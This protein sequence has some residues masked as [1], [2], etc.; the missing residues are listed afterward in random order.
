[1]PGTLRL[2]NGSQLTYSAAKRLE[3]NVIHSLRYHNLK[4]ALYTR[5]A[6]QEN[7]IQ[8][9]AAHHLGLRLSECKVSKPVD[10][11]HGSCNLC[12]PID[13]LRPGRHACTRVIMRFPLA[14]RVGE[15]FRPGNSDEKLRTEAGTYAWLQENCPAVPIPRLYGF[16]LSTGQSVGICP[17]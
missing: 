15:D 10:W 12:V 6:R 16:A 9:A 8:A 1:M 14:Y 5:L 17:V 3:I 11:I 7:L 2:H 13:I 4:A